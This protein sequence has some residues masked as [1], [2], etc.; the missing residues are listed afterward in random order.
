MESSFSG[1]SRGPVYGDGTFTR[2]GAQSS[3]P[4]MRRAGL[5]RRTARLYQQR[6]RGHRRRSCLSGLG[7]ERVYALDGS[8][9]RTLYTFVDKSGIRASPLTYRVSGK[10]Y[11]AVVATD[12][13]IALS[14]P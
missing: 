12:K 3:T 1:G 4:L 13:M 10:Q 5:A 2:M 9:G 8:I 6:Q 7:D 11:V 14:L